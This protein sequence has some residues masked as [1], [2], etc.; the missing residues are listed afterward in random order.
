M[1]AT[2]RGVLC[3][4]TLWFSWG[5]GVVKGL[6]FGFGFGDGNWGGLRFVTIDW[7]RGV[8]VCFKDG[9]IIVLGEGVNGYGISS[10]SSICILL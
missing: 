1:L 3:A 9:C 7:R 10:I 5:W 6:G 8:W 2:V 4:C